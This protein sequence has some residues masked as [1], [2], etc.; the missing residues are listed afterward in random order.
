MSNNN[1]SG[2]KPKDPMVKF[3]S[4]RM[5]QNS[6]GGE[7]IVLSLSPEEVDYLVEKVK[8]GATER[9]VNLDIHITERSTND[10]SRNFLSGIA[11]IRGIQEFGAGKQ[12][13]AV[14]QKQSSALR[15][16]VASLKTQPGVKK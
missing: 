11:F 13:Q 3:K 1:N 16:R 15:D 5:G 9:G 7:R 8:E 14:P 4:V 2:E 6:K 12:Q 10:G